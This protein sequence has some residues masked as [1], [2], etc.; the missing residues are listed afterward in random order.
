MAAN[1]EKVF[2][3]FQFI[4]GRFDGG[5]V[6]EWPS[7]EC[8]LRDCCHGE[9]FIETEIVVLPSKGHRARQV[10]HKMAPLEKE[11]P[12]V[13]FVS[14]MEW[15]AFER[16][17]EE[18]DAEWHA[19]KA[20]VRQPIEDADHRSRGVRL[21]DLPPGLS[22]R[23]RVDGSG[24][25]LWVSRSRRTSLWK[26][27]RLNR[28]KRKMYGRVN[29]NGGDWAAHRL[30]Y[31]LTVGEIPKGAILLHSCDTPACVNPAHLMLGIIEDNVRDMLAKGRAAWQK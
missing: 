19:E 4:D 3:V 17:C 12:G 7:A 8:A 31:T 18:A 24:C 26:P 1:L 13:R 2:H 6:G 29:F 28:V 20:R 10:T 30:V 14:V 23:I 9:P 21:D 11:H 16:M 15:G 22:S 25:W 5:I 27:Q